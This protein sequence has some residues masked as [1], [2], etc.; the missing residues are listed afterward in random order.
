M[1]NVDPTDPDKAAQRL[2]KIFGSMA[3][4]EVTRHIREMER[5]GDDAKLAAWEDVARALQKR[6]FTRM[7][8]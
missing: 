2:V 6:G 7:W 1:S 4:R 5:V 3:M 8:W